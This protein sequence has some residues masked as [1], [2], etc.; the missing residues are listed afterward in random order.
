RASTALDE[1]FKGTPLQ[2]IIKT[3]SAS[4][5]AFLNTSNPS[6]PQFDVKVQGEIDTPVVTGNG[7]LDVQNSGI[8]MNG[9]FSTALGTVNFSG[10]GDYQ[11]NINLTGTGS[12]NLGPLHAGADFHM[13]STPSGQF[14]VTA[15]AHTDLNLKVID[16][17]V[18][19]NFTMNNGG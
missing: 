10:S 1:I 19:A 6:A 12:A 16:P 5:D 14:S 13:T 11:G 7:T 8:S 9:N 2:N 15:H 17:M 18:D 4:I 3:P